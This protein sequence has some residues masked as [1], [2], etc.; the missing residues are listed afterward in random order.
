MENTFQN[1]HSKKPLLWR[2]LGRLPA[3]L[4]NKYFLAGAFF[5]VW[6]FFFD[7]KDIPSGI[8]RKQKL[9]ELQES[10]R[11]LDEMIT[12]A[13]KELQLLKNDAQSIEKYAREKY[14]MKKDNEDLFIVTPPSKTE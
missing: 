2:G 14:M 5:L 12:N 9:N 8:E 3:W 13:E 1:V 10:E 6:M 11:H 4:K 7:P